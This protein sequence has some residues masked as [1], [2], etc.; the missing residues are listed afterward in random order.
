MNLDVNK[1][2][3]LWISNNPLTVTGYALVTREVCE[4]LVE[5][6]NVVVLSNNY[7]GTPIN[8]KGFWVRQRSDMGMDLIQ[9][10]IDNLKPE[11]VISLDDTF[12]QFREN[13][14]RIDFKDSKLVMYVPIDGDRIPFTGHAVLDKADAIVPMSNYAKD[15]I[16]KEGYTCEDAIWHGVDIKLH[17]PL[18]KEE[19]T[20]IRKNLGFTDNDFVIFNVAR[21][22]PR[23]MNMLL[24]LAQA[25]IAKRNPRVK[26]FNHISMANS[27]DMNL[28]DFIQRVI[29]I[30]YGEEY[31]GLLGT[32]I[33]FSPFAQSLNT[34]VDDAMMAKF[35]GMA[36]LHLSCTSGEGFGLFT[37]QSEACGVPTVCTDFTTT[38]ELVTHT[39]VGQCGLGIKP[40][41]LLYS[42]F[43]V[44]H[45]LVDIDDAVVQVEKMMKSKRLYEKCKKNSLKFVE[46]HLDWDVIS[47]EWIALLDK[48]EKKTPTNVLEEGINVVKK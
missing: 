23:K 11:Y 3:I 12:S 24:L 15:E 26:F 16:E 33:L 18:G 42:S 2:T 17:K 35:Y 48:V 5:K 13:M 40:S 9:Q 8:Y 14:H 7:I 41:A 36:D 21:N 27:V 47:K 6:Y 39:P 32:Q 31:K 10:Y 37:V 1:P 19:K 20:K 30:E 22:S 28:P 38:K 45:A 4:R 46:K 25:K 43:G 34:G 29:P 44:Q